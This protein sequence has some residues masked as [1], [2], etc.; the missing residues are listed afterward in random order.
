M[1][2]KQ[3][4]SR[5]VKQIRERLKEAGWLSYKIHGSA[6]QEPGI[7]DLLCFRDGKPLAIEAKVG[8]NAPTAIQLRQHARLRAAG[9][10]VVVAYSVEDLVAYLD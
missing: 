6:Y 8:S 7:P 10:E 9:V 5:L 2:K 4:E 1:A 3:T